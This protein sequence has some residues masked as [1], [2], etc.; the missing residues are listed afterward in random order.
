ML[1]FLTKIISLVF[2]LINIAN[3]E[4]LKKIEINGNKRISDETIKIFSNLEN[5][6]LIDL[7]V[8]GS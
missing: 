3:A 2:F 4:I 7:K 6:L 5:F 8:S 1:G